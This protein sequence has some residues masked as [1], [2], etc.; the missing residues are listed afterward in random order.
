MAFSD[1]GIFLGDVSLFEINHFTKDPKKTQ[2][3]TLKKILFMNKNCEYGR[4]YNFADIHSI[5]DYQRMVPLSTYEDYAPYV[6]RMIRHKEKNLMFTGLNIRYCSSSGSVGKPKIL[7]KSANDLW[8]MQC[9]GFSVSVATAAHW[10]KKHKNIKLPPQMGPLVLILTGHR[11]EDG[12]KCNGAGQIPLDYLKHITRFFCTSPVSLLLPEHEELIDTSYLQLRFALENEDVSYIGSMVVT[13]LTTMFDYL[14]EHWQMLCDDI[15]KG[16]INPSVKITP[17]LY[18][19]YS[20]KFKPN[21]A[22]ATALRREFEKGFDTPIAPRI[23]PKLTWGYSMMGSNLSVYIDKLRKAVGDL[24]LHNMGYAAAE[25]YFATP[26]ELNVSDAVLLPHCL[27]FEFLPVNAG[28]ECADENATPLL[29]HQLE[30]GKD[31][32]LI[33]SN[34]SGL[35]RYRTFDVF[36]VTRM[37]NNTPCVELLY[38]QN[39]SMNVAN[40]KTTTQMVDHVAKQVEKRMGVEF[41]GHSYFPDFSTKPPH[42]TLLAELKGAPEIDEATRQQFIEVLDDELCKV[43]EK[44]DKYRRWGM[45]SRPEMLFLNEKTYWDYRES[46]RTRG[47]VLNQI[48]PVTVI[49]TKE[50]ERFFFEHVATK[51][52]VVDFVLNGGEAKTVEESKPAEDAAPTEEE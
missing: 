30:V 29:L 32:E 23:W 13:L 20:K 18:K 15:E 16:I 37:Y 49:N 10:L 33:V 7:P 51:A 24:P 36:R 4:R 35:Y 8:K 45:L 3:S 31:Y 5:E 27:F 42:Y 21:P 47:V 2:Q 17:E 43:N 12:K 25:G 41:V 50:R 26:T 39:L 28:D 40:E 48:K 46:L 1:F 9:I 11:L 34:Y 52:D 44:Y 6:D 22:R 19:K 38:R 14:E